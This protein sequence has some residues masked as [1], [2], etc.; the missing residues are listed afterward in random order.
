MESQQSDTHLLDGWWHDQLE[1]I[2]EEP[3]SRVITFLDL[4]TVPRA[5]R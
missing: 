3:I 1:M 2:A 5:I 4:C